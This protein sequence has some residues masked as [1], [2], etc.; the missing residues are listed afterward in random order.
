MKN[1]TQN[2]LEGIYWHG[3]HVYDAFTAKEKKIRS[4]NSI[5]NVNLFLWKTTGM[6]FKLE[7]H[8]EKYKA[9]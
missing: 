2:M 5:Y 7:K 6:L 9:K 4:Q 1:D 3:K 8:L